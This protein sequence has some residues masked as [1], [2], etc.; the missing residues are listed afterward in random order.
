MPMMAMPPGHPNPPS[1]YLPAPGPSLLSHP[2]FG[3]QKEIALNT[4]VCWC[5]SFCFSCPI[6]SYPGGLRQIVPLAF[7]FHLTKWALQL[8]L[9]FFLAL[10]VCFCFV[11]FFC[12]SKAF[13]WLV[14]FK[15]ANIGAMCTKLCDTNDAT[16]RGFW[17]RYQEPGRYY[18]GPLTF[19]RGVRGHCAEYGFACVFTPAPKVL[20][21][22]ERY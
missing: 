14:F 2:L 13:R 9:S 1:P 3:Q 16:T 22:K 21:H 12:L 6:A 5:L 15:S 20:S 11:C 18:Q 10:L 4:L 19:L 8:H 17:P 7:Y